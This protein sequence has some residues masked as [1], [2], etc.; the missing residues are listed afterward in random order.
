MKE[1]VIRSG[2]DSIRHVTGN[3]YLAG[4]GRCPEKDRLWPSGDW[5]RCT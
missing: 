5:Q 3:K 2:I 1:S 4:T